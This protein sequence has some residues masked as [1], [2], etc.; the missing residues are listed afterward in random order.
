MRWL[1]KIWLLNRSSFIQRFLCH[2]KSF[3]DSEVEKRSF[4]HRSWWA[5]WICRL[6]LPSG[7][8][9]F[10]GWI[11]VVDLF[12]T[13][14]PYVLPGVGAPFLRICISARTGPHLG[15]LRKEKMSTV[16]YTHTHTHTHTLSSVGGTPF[17]RICI[18]ARA[19]PHLGSLCKE[20]KSTVFNTHSSV[21]E[22][23]LDTLKHFSYQ[24][25]ITVRSFLP[26]FSWKILR[27]LL[28]DSEFTS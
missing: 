10:L 3:L 8:K 19:G 14:V 15:S 17:L 25:K 22:C 18:S 4:T 24:T 12:I 7:T 27:C 26:F 28:Q 5:L 9:A 23:F 16:I 1:T 6:P 11:A 13:Y 21:T 20:R 2:P